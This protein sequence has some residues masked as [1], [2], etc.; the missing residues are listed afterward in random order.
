MKTYLYKMTG[1]LGRA[2]IHATYG[3]V[4]VRDDQDEVDAERKAMKY[5]RELDDQPWYEIKILP[6][7]RLETIE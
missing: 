7:I 3:L 1:I 4:V 2:T 5:H 6:L